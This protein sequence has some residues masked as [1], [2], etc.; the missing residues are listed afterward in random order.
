MNA[1]ASVLQERPESRVVALLASLIDKHDLRSL[2]EV[3]LTKVAAGTPSIIRRMSDDDKQQV[4]SLFK[5]GKRPIDIAVAIGFSCAA[6]TKELERQ[7]LRERRKIIVKNSVFCAHG[8][9]K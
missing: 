8:T 3:P 9:P 5:Q 7:G 1:L 2:P 6:V 4:V